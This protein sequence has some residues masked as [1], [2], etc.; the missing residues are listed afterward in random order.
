MNKKAWRARRVVVQRTNERDLKTILF[1]PAAII[2][3]RKRANSAW[4]HVNVLSFVLAV[5]SLGSSAV[6]TTELLK[7]CGPVLTVI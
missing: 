6:N 3:Y 5:E 2:D 1:F 7:D 4:K